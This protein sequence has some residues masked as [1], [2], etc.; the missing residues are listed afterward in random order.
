V[1]HTVNGKEVSEKELFRNYVIDDPRIARMIAETN[2][3]INHQ[4]ISNKS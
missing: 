1:T 4:R 2:R 3:R